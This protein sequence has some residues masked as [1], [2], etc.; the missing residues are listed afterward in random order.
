MK[1]TYLPLLLL[2]SVRL[3][4]ADGGT[5]QL[6]KTVGPFFVTVFSEPVPLRVGRADLSVLCQRLPDKTPVLDATVLFHLRKPGAGDI[7]TYTIPARHSD[8]KNKLLYA[9]SLD[10]TSSGPWQFAVDIEQNHALVST[11][12]TLK[13]LNKEPPLATYWPYFVMLPLIVILFS[14]NRW[15]RRRH[16]I[17]R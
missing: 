4:P 5:V 12:G 15:L 11:Y 3:L 9:A 16:R 10:F 2:L 1:T 14:V 6:Q 7:V 13:V 17:R 8:A